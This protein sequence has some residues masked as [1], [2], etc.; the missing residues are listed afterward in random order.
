M[1]QAWVREGD[2][3]CVSLTHRSPICL[4]KAALPRAA[5][6]QRQEPTIM[7]NDPYYFYAVRDLNAALESEKRG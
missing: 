3:F 7:A 5:P 6:G 1:E 2:V 4:C